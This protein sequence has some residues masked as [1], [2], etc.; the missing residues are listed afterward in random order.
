MTI[1]KRIQLPVDLCTITKTG[2]VSTLHDRSLNIPRHFSDFGVVVGH[3][4]T[5]T[6]NSFNMTNYQTWTNEELFRTK[7]DGLDTPCFMGSHSNSEPGGHLNISEY[8][9]KLI[10]RDILTT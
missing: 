5:G 2:T 7:I 8:T 1:E 6:T 3:G 4:R 9:E 10:G